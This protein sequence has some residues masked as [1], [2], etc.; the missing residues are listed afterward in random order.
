MPL[1]DGLPIMCKHLTLSVLGKDCTKR[2]V[3]NYRMRKVRKLRKT[4]FDMS[5]HFRTFRTFR[6]FSLPFEREVR[7][8]SLISTLYYDITMRLL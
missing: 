7:R 1:K 5:Y 2:Y 4:V 6:T 8:G 3:F